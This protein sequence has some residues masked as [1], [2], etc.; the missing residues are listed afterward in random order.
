M[1][2]YTKKLK[3]S[4]AFLLSL[5]FIVSSILF[6]GINQVNAAES[7]PEK[8]GTVTITLNMTLGEGVAV[9]N[10]GFSYKVQ[11]EDG[12]VVEQG[13]ETNKVLQVKSSYSMI[14]QAMTAGQ[15]IYENG[16]PMDDGMQ[17]K[18]EE[19]K[20]INLSDGNQTFNFE[21][22]PKTGGNPS[23]EEQKPE[24]KN[25]ETIKLT[26]AEGGNLLE[27]SVLLDG[28]PVKDGQVT[29]EKKANHDIEFQVAFG[30]AV[31]KIYVN[32][33]SCEITDLGMDRLQ[34]T[35]PDAPS[36]TIRLTEAQSDNLT[37]M[38]SYKQED[39]NTDF[40]V[41]H[42]KVE[43][44]SVK[45]GDE[46]VYDEN[47]SSENISIDNN[48]GWVALKRGDD[49][50]IRLIPDYGYQVKSVVVN[51]VDTLQ[52]QNSVSTFL[53]K[54]I[55]GNMHLR[56]MFVEQADTI[57]NNSAVFD[58]V[59][60][61]NGANAVSSGN[62]ELNIKDDEQASS[63]LD[64]AGILNHSA[65]KVGTV[66]ITLDNVVSKGNGKSGTDGNWTTSITEFSEPIKV[67]LTLGDA[68]LGENEEFVVLRKHGN[69][70]VAVINADF[71]ET[72]KE[73]EFETNK[74]S[75]YVVVK[76]ITTPEVHVHTYTTTR[77]YDDTNHWYECTAPDCPDADKGKKG[78]EA[79]V[80]ISLGHGKESCMDC[81]YELGGYS[82]QATTPEKIQDITNSE[83]IPVKNQVTVGINTGNKS[84][85]E[86]FGISDSEKSQGVNVWLKSEDITNTVS[87]N[88][89]QLIDNKKGSAKVGMYLDLSLYKK[90]G[91]D[92]PTKV[93]D[94]NEQI[95]V[96]VDLPASLIKDNRTYG[97]VR[98]HNGEAEKLPS[99][100][101]AGKLKIKTNG[102]STY[103]IVYEDVPESTNTG[104]ATDT[105]NTTTSTSGNTTSTS[106]TGYKSPKTGDSSNSM[107]WAFFAIVFVVSAV[108][109][110]K[111][112]S[113][114]HS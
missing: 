25:P 109:V 80:F 59:K 13:F 19:G 10:Y 36:Y 31:G 22:R 3:Q 83:I 44:V 8:A 76:K 78:V 99:S 57:N 9:E 85:A 58:A 33:V 5:T 51:D 66:D 97:A 38:W 55:Q 104:S 86:I 41:E 21:L 48:G 42:G 50:T 46:I 92:D 63:D 34:V 65:E 93:T 60:I 108:I 56:G 20:V 23:D 14:I 62:L 7:T 15:K 28:K 37:I 96:T 110:K 17:A 67:S 98:V 52:P 94:L 26:I 75:T 64:V 100:Y 101:N 24:I 12:V 114:L 27:G 103:A 84:L 70:D 89:K 106:N 90:V 91:T 112:E 79:H 81:A 29:V 77:K 2:K 4:L 11:N 74:F 95:E 61:A 49:I 82:G 53:L 69:E 71:N 39:K 105:G 102:F 1:R 32:D 111:K 45:R 18:W 30:S 16:N 40:Y 47:S 107:L 6:S 43:L 68:D 54:N 113:Y 72:T 87:S 88:D 35:V 73:I